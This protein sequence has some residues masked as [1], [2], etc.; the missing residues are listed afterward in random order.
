MYL[1]LIYIYLLIFFLKSFL[2][3]CKFEFGNYSGADLLERL[4]AIDEFGL[5]SLYE[6]MIKYFIENTIMCAIHRSK[7]LIC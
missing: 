3:T 1:I 5:E 2:Y 4:I 6:Y 7:C